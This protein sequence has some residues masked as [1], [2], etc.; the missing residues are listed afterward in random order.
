MIV[1]E[2]LKQRHSPGT[3]SHFWFIEFT[4]YLFHKHCCDLVLSPFPLRT[5]T[6]HRKFRRIGLIAR[7]SVRNK[8]RQ[9]N[10]SVPSPRQLRRVVFMLSGSVHAS[11]I[12]FDRY[13]FPFEIDIVGRSGESR[14]NITYHGRRMDNTELLASADAL[15]ING[16]Y[17]AVSEAFVLRKPV[18]VVPVPGH[19]EQ[20]VNSCLVRDLGLGFVATENDVLSQL[21]TACEENR[22]TGLKPAPPSIE[23]NGAQE[24]AQTI[25]AVATVHTEPRPARVPVDSIIPE[26]TLETP[27][28][29]VHRAASPM[30][31]S[32]SR[33]QRVR[34][35]TRSI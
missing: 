9:A 25:L 24:A 8:A 33:G 21:Q 22:W 7:R 2:Y 27:P 3:R 29:P 32:R 31:S 10:R 16:G 34:Q 28:A 6:R 35:P 5:P 20:F 23:T 11:K 14:A 1:T 17:S 26:M 12:S 15:V 30:I 4:D 13:D 19:A 18:F